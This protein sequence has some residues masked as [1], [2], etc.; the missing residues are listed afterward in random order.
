ME[1]VELDPP[2]VV[3]PDPRRGRR[4]AVA[5]PSHH[6]GG[7]D[8]RAVGPPP[9][10]LRRGGDAGGLVLAEGGDVA[11]QHGSDPV[12]GLRL[13]LARGRAGEGGL[14]QLLVQMAV[15]HGA[16]EAAD[17]ADPRREGLGLRRPAGVG[18]ELRLQWGRGAEVFGL[19]PVKSPPL[20]GPRPLTVLHVSDQ[21]WKINRNH[22]QRF[23]LSFADK[24]N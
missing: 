12:R 5:L 18:V 21:S 9:A 19:G 15:G 6:Q 11:V 1:P 17:G 23:D 4:Q 20:F 7:E 3:R 10:P 2:S 13:L 16:V 22:D 14:E 8:R 24:R